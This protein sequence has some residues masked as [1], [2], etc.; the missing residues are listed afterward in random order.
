MRPWLEAKVQ[1]GNIPGLSWIDQEK[2]IFKVPWKHGGKHDWNEG[3]STIF[4]VP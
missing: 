3:D 2:K 4:K 1:A